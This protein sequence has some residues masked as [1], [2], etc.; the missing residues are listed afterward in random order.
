MSTDDDAD[1]YYCVPFVEPHA[2]FRAFLLAHPEADVE[3]TTTPD[4]RTD[5]LFNTDRTERLFRQWHHAV[6]AAA[7][8]PQRGA[9]WWGAALDPWGW[10]PV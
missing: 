1:A 9:L 2:L 6:Q 3:W 5:I 8:V 7:G 10:P 4:G